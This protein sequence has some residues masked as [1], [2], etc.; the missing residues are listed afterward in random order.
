MKTGHER[1]HKTPALTVRRET[2][3]APALKASYP[4]RLEDLAVSNRALKREIVRRQ[5]VEES[6]KNSEQRKNQLLEELRTLSH[7]LLQ[8]QEEERKRISRELHD[9][10]TQTLMS[11]TVQLETL[12]RAATVNPSALKQ[13][14]ARTQ[15]LVVKSVN[16]VHQ[17]ARELRPTG[18]DDLGLIVTLHE[19]L[20]EFMKR[21][22]IR[23]HYTTFAEADQ[24]SSDQRTVIYR[25]VKEA[26]TNVAQHAH[27]SQVNVDLCKS[28]DTVQLKISDN[29]QA[30]DVKRVL[31]VKH[32]KR[33]GLIG[34]RERAEMVGGTFT[35]E[36]TPGKGTT[37]LAQIPFR[38]D[39]RELP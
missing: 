39:R 19:A 2:Q 28:V 11:I 36:S 10:I 35:I 32:N 18:L 38:N 29:G 37:V 8:V 1:R 4:R 16:I 6:L 7:R 20:N 17:F 23:V 34:M 27:A 15:R 30:F 13:K 33:L 9:E 24:L 3:A 21:T 5:A 26:L 25:I 12:V 14:I 31:N 22:G